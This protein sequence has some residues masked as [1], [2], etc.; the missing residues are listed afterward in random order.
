MMPRQQV[1]AF[2]ITFPVKKLCG[3][4]VARK[5]DGDFHMEDVYFGDCT[6]DMRF[7]HLQQSFR[8]SSLVMNS[9]LSL[10][11]CYIVTAVTFLILCWQL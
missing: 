8:E 4:F 1:N 5:G 7:C 2:K 6:G 10:C 3:N 11:G 9:V